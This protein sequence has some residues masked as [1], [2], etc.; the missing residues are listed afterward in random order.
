VSYLMSQ[1][2]TPKPWLVNRQ[3]HQAASA[4]KARE[5]SRNAGTERDL[6][7]VGVCFGGSLSFNGSDVEWER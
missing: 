2:P 4:G 7:L 3:S 1:R 5:V 6:D